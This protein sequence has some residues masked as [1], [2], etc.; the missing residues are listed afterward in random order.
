MAA[1]LAEFKRGRGQKIYGK[2]PY[3]KP[4]ASSKNVNSST[5]GLKKP[6]RDTV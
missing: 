5:A 3:R 2:Y 6:P 4:V 1:F